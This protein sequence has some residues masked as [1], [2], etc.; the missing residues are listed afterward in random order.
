S[1]NGAGSF[2]FN[3][4]YTQAGIFNV[5]FKATDPSSAVD[6]EVVQITVNNVNNAPILDSIGSKSVNE[7]QVLTFRVHATDINGDR[8]ILSTLNVPTNATFTDSTNGAG[9]FTFSPNYTQAG[10]YNVTFVVTDTAGSVDSEVVAI[11]VVS[12]GDQAP[13]LDSIGAKSVNEGSNLT[14]RLHATDADGDS[15]I[16]N[17][18]SIPTNAI[19]TD[20]ANEAGS[21]IFNPNYT[22]AG[23]YN[24]TFKATDPSLAVDSEIVQITVNNVNRSPVLDSIGTKSVKEG[25]HL[26]FRVHAIDADGDLLVLTAANL[27]TNSSFIDSG[28]GA[29]SFSFNPDY[30]QVG[31]HNVTFKTIDPL[32]AVDSEVVQITVSNVN[33]PPVLNPI[34]W[35]IV[36]EAETL[37]FNISAYDPDG[38]IPILYTSALP[39]NAMFIDNGNGT[40]TF[41]F[42]PNY[43]QQGLKDVIFYASD[44]SSIDNE[45]VLIQVVDAGNQRPIM[46]TIPPDSV[47]EGDTL[48]ILV[49]ADDPDSTIPRLSTG[50]LEPYMVFTDSGNGNGVLMFTPVYVQS[51]VY[52][53]RFIASDGSLAD[54]ETVLITVL[55]AG[56]QPPILS[57]PYDS[58][59]VNEDAILSFRIRGI[60]PD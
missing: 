8:L 50:T 45:W 37:T 29:S 35:K 26:T 46:Q 20:S 27:P 28:N 10:I 58:T 19:F 40:G 42:M 43:A 18:T 34:G 52:G 5:T 14:F 30:N 49:H 4:N 53:I 32:L 55:E 11:T 25:S 15:I 47:T 54:T 57:I 16:L 22:Q 21:F 1:G 31:V 9:S 6:S 56:N 17:A 33:R 44:G 23:V 36:N 38:I 7:G 2:S 48:I 24:V 41:T 3:P 60:D 13:V 12:A 51:G 39:R 59:S